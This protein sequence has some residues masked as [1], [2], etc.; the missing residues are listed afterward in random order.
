MMYG[1]SREDAISNLAQAIEVASSLDPPYGVLHASNVDLPEIFNRKQ[2]RPDRYV[3]KEFCEFV[4]TVAA[5]FP[6]G[7][8]PIRL[9]MENLWWPGLRLVD[10]RGF[11]ILERDL[12]FDNWG[13]CLDTG[14]LMSCLPTTSE[15][16][17]IDRL[18]KVFDGYPSD[19]LERIGTVHLHW[20]A[21]YEYR[22]SFDERSIDNL[23]DALPQMTEHVK[24][25]DRHLPF[26]DP[27]CR[28]LIDA[29]DP[30][31]VT[32]EMP[33]S[34]TGVLED[35]SKQRALF[36]RAENSFYRSYRYS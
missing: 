32:H 12:E 31:Y 17:G 9:Q 29:L 21:S 25:I 16:D 6:K 20:S 28:E 3:L 22:M 35:F 19:L 15:V 4:N 14:H 33:G 1:R 36:Q 18:L 11:R 7:E 8:P 24:A 13:I 23:E 34:E 30:E 10:D 2:T 26:S 5:R 27:R